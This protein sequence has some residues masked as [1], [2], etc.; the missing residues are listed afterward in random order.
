M[1]DKWKYTLIFWDISLGFKYQIKDHNLEDFFRKLIVNS[2]KEF[3]S[4]M[5]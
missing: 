2:K 3:E 5:V 1:C 4:K